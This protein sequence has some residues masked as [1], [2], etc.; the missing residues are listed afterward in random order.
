MVLCKCCVFEGYISFASFDVAIC[1]V[2]VLS[3]LVCMSLLM[4]YVYSQCQMSCSSTTVIIH[5]G[6]C[7]GVNM[8]KRTMVSTVLCS[9]VW[10]VVCDVR[11][12]SSVFCPMWRE[13]KWVCMSC[14]D[15]FFCIGMDM[16]LTTIMWYDVGAIFV[17]L[18]E[19]SYF[20][21][22]VQKFEIHYSVSFI[23]YV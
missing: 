2:M 16:M 21:V 10:N 6:G 15:W 4:F 23:W 1:L 11:K 8:L 18:Y 7:N 22:N 20:K 14:L 9:D 19:G 5:D 12:Y 3:M 17:L 13:M